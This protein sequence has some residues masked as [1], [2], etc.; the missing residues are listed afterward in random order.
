MISPLTNHG[1]HTR[2]EYLVRDPDIEMVEAKASD[3]D[4][5]RGPCG[6]PQPPTKVIPPEDGQ[7]GIQELQNLEG[8]T[9]LSR[10]QVRAWKQVEGSQ[11]GVAV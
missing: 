3:M 9:D 1:L 10:E 11:V 5:E 6:E 2:A 7:E 8:A 4:D